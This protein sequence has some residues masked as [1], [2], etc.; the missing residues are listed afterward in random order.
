MA[1]VYSF[2]REDRP[3]VGEDFF[4]RGRDPRRIDRDDLSGRLETVDATANLGVI[5]AEIDEI[6][7]QSREYGGRHEIDADLAP[8]VHANIQ[9]TRRQAANDGL[10]HWMTTMWRPD[11]VRFRWPY[12]DTQ[13]TES[14]MREK[15]FGGGSEIYTNAFGRLWWMAELT[16][17]ADAEDPYDIT[18]RALSVQSLANRLFDPAFH[19][20][21]PAVQ[22]FAEVL[23]DRAVEDESVDAAADLVN[24]ANVRFNQVLSSVQ[25]ETQG[26]DALCAVVSGIVEDLKRDHQY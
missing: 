24:D 3:L 25:L 5:E 1:D 15:F 10:W 12:D 20:Y 18:R 16:H 19:R 2:P 8:V 4:Y 22:A 21:E 7:T 6:V 9:V 14:S 11:F 23:L 13:R 26:T 17:R